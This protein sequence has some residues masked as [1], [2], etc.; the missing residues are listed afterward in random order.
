MMINNLYDDKGRLKVSA[1]QLI[2]FTNCK[3]YW[4]INKI[5]GVQTKTTPALIYGSQFHSC[6]ETSYELI[7]EGLGRKDLNKALVVKKYP[8]EIIEMVNVGWDKKILTIP[9]KKLIE[10]DFKI[11]VKDY[12][13]MRGAIDFYNITTNTIEDHKTVGNWKYALTKKDLKNNLQ[14]MIYCYWAMTK[15]PKKKSIKV[16]HNQFFK[17]APSESCFIEDEVTREYVMMYWKIN[18]EPVVAEMVEYCQKRSVDDVEG[19]LS[20][21]GAYGGCCF[22]NNS[23]EM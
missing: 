20:H 21:C 14:L 6:I 18:V 19:N 1:S 11:P 8:D 12:G 23:C 3:K 15:L 10:K 4:Y 16:R 17:L 7:Q 22:K 9:P 2:S 13:I 5:M